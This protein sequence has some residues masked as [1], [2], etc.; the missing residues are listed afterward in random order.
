VRRT[1]GGGAIV[2]DAELTYCFTAPCEASLRLRAAGL[3]ASFH[4]TLIDCLAEFGV[5]ATQASRAPPSAQRP[6][7]LCFQRREA[8][9][10]VIDSCK[11]AG[12]AQ[13][14]RRQSILQHGSVLLD[15]SRCAPELPGI[16][17]LTGAP[18]E[19]LALAERWTRRLEARLGCVFTAAALTKTERNKAS[20]LEN[21]VFSAPSWTRRR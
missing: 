3:Y 10:V 8:G 6:P 7:F 21:E 13:R 20:G 9:D 2:H 5:A 12:S 4:E 15:A 11:V 18:I 16:K 1:T 17:E 14:R 19:P